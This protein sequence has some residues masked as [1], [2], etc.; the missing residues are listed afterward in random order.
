MPPASLLRRDFLR[1][2]AASPA[3]SL[4]GADPAVIAR[5]EEAINVLDFEAA[6]RKALPP[7]HWGY[8]ATGV[9]DDATLRANREGFARVYLRPRRL[10]DISG[11][12][13]RTE[14]F[15]AVWHSPLGLAPVGNQ[16]AF[17]A[18]GEAPVAR[19]AAKTDTL[20]VLS[21]ATNTSIE[22]VAK[23]LGRPPWYQLYPS[24]RWEVTEYLVRRVEAAGCPVMAL[25][26]DTQAGRRTETFERFRVQDER[27]C[28]ACHGPEPGDFFRR[29]PMFSGVQT[30][31][32]R[33]SNPALNWE[34]V[35]RLRKLTGMKFLIK[36]LETAEDTRLAIDNGADG[37][38]VSNHGGRA[39][40]SGRGTIECLPEVVEAAAGRIPVL[41]DGGIRRGADVFKALAL[42]ARMVFIG[43]PYLWGL[44]AFGQ[45]GVERVIEMLNA[46]LHLVMRQCGAVSI[47]QVTRD[48]VGLRG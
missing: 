24:S 44:A 25:T 36:G 6:A 31:G 32:L 11:G 42:G 21:T 8:L 43:R 17:H 22:D 28:A 5:P 13:S 16:K 29:K 2:L 41:L 26:V 4:A 14:L 48:L 39:G 30:A 45:A 3:A 47:R 40:E 46:E 12:D 33:T 1:Y 9:E 35:R 20:Q 37:V 15:G 23:L 34:H 10:V 27:P 38:I 18:E 19:A 7:A